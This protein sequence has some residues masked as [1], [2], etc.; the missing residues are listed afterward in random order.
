MIQ[1]NGL[2]FPKGFGKKVSDLDKGADHDASKHRGYKGLYAIEA[3]TD[4]IYFGA[5]PDIYGVYF[6]SYGPDPVNKVAVEVFAAFDEVNPGRDSEYNLDGS[7]TK[8]GMCYD[9]Y[10]CY[11]YGQAALSLY[12]TEVEPHQ[13]RT[14]K[15]LN[16]MGTLRKV[17]ASQDIDTEGMDK[18]TM[19]SRIEQ[20]IA[21]PDASKST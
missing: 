8:E 2:N 3:D 12:V 9:G 5:A 6:S 14:L 16:T 1:K 4:Q 11:G 15:P 10:A 20:L 17:L 18:G 13:V 19:K 7:S 21:R